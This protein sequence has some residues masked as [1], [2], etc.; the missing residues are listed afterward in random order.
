MIEKI[1]ILQHGES[2]YLSSHSSEETS[3]FLCI[4][5]YHHELVIELRKDRLNSLSK[6]LVGPC[7]R[8]P[9]LLVQP[10]RDIEGDVGCLKQV[11]LHRRTQIPLVPKYRAVVVL[12]LH[13]LEILQ[14]MHIGCCH[15]IGMNYSADTAQGMKLVAVIVHVLRGAVTPGWRMLY[16]VL[17]HLTP[18]S[19]GILTD[20]YRLRVYAEDV[21][22]SIY[23][24][25]YGFTNIFTQQHSLL[26]TL[27][28]LP[29]TDQVGNGTRAFSIQT[30]EE[31]IL[32]VNT[33]C[34]CRDGE[35]HH[36]Q[37][38]EGGYN[39]TSRY[40]SF[41]IYLISCK[42]LAYLKNFSEL[43]D[44]VAHIYDH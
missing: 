43:C 21:F 3:R 42:F 2:R 1:E 26:A 11:Q 20:L 10:V 15:I 25:G 29:T 12:P 34:L 14:V 27:V 17:T 40:I 38:G 13:I 44:E 4:I 36:L 41:L 39:T 23:L 6:T 7:G 8:C 9:I 31:V 16:V 19:T 37:I 24:F 22:A 28:V 30:L 33:Q 35:S 5:A 32:T 18:V